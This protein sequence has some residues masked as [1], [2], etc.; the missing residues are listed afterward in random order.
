MLMRQIFF[1]QGIQRKFWKKMEFIKNDV[2]L[3]QFMLCKNINQY[4]N[5]LC[6]SSSDY[7]GAEIWIGKLMRGRNN[8]SAHSQL[9]IVLTSTLTLNA[10][11]L[12]IVK[13]PNL[14]LESAACVYFKVTGTWWISAH[15]WGPR[16][17]MHCET[18][19][20]EVCGESGTNYQYQSPDRPLAGSCFRRPHTFARAKKRSWPNANN[21]VLHVSVF[22]LVAFVRSRHATGEERACCVTRPNSGS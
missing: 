14:E 2:L 10:L 17:S 20:G 8:T 16:L 9:N 21:E 22:S 11:L 3:W 4:N 12:C 13:Q 7:E 19:R 1:I 15:P 6:K 5:S 18:S